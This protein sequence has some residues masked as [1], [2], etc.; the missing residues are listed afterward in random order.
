LSPTRDDHAEFSSA[1]LGHVK[2]FR[3]FRTAVR[4]PGPPRRG[5]PRTTC[6]SWGVAR[7]W[8]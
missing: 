5:A 8:R 7:A 2:R 3:V 6:G 1:G 4:S